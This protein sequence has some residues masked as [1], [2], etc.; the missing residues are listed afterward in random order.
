VL[1][2]VPFPTDLTAVL[3]VQLT[4]PAKHGVNLSSIDAVNGYFNEVTYSY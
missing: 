2:D 4:D 3:P 1:A